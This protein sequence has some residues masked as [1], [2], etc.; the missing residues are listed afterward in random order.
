[1]S[2]PQTKDSKVEQFQPEATNG[3]EDFLDSVSSAAKSDVTS[4]NDLGRYKLTNVVNKYYFG[5]TIDLKTR[6][7][8]H[9]SKAKKLQTH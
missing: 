9:K 4:K 1:M 8:R 3:L 6:L 2:E 7:G 5:Q